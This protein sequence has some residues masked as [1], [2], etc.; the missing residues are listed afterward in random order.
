MSEQRLKVEA[1]ILKRIDE[2]RPSNPKKSDYTHGI[3]V[4][5]AMAKVAIKDAPTIEERKTGKWIEVEVFPESYD[6][7][8][9]K[10]WSSKMQCNQ[11]GFRHTAIEGH[12]AQYNFCPN[13]G[14]RMKKGEDNGTVD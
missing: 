9:N 12:M 5:L 10:T 11:C 4:G 7:Y 2:I 8:G 3:D 6:I 14:A 1:E 13:C